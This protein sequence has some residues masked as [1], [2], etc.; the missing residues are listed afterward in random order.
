MALA[1]KPLLCLAAGSSMGSTNATG[2]Q[3][4]ANAMDHCSCDHPPILWELGQKEEASALWP[5]GGKAEANL[6]YLWCLRL[7][8]TGLLF[9]L[10]ARLQ[11]EGD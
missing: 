8:K 3:V 2:K 5:A 10:L 6:L 9:F 1:L 4:L 7:K 11:P